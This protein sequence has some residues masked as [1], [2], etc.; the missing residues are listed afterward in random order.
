MQDSLHRTG[1]LAGLEKL[2]PRMTLGSWSASRPQLALAAAALRTI[3][4]AIAG[5][6]R[7]AGS[8]LALHPLK[9]LIKA[10]SLPAN[11][12]APV[13]AMQCLQAL[14]AADAG[15]RPAVVAAGGVGALSRALQG[16]RGGLAQGQSEDLVEAA[17]RT[18][19]CVA[20]GDPGGQL[21]AVQGAR[22]TRATLQPI[23]ALDP[24]VRIFKSC[25]RTLHR[26]Q[27]SGRARGMCSKGSVTRREEQRPASAGAPAWR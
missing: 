17:V 7:N 24:A 2:I 5:H 22:M 8:F 1:A 6:P 15:V 18:L 10:V 9:H 11:E 26:Q 21:E 13:A 27:W 19:A 20:V 16:A 12:A 4:A 25:W 23:P 14:C 3:T